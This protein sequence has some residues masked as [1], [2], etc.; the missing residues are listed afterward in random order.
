MDRD[1]PDVIKK[2]KEHQKRLHSAQGRCANPLSFSSDFFTLKNQNLH[3][4]EG[5]PGMYSSAVV[6]TKR[7]VNVVP[8]GGISENVEQV[9][10]VETDEWS[11]EQQKLLE[12]GLKKH[13]KDVSHRWDRINADVVG[14]DKVIETSIPDKLSR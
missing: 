4:I 7:Q 5:T 8:V 11:Q 14:K 10:K 1:V 13:G 9:T 3:H 6:K 2:T 12:I